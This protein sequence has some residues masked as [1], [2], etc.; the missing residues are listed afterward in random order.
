MSIDAIPLGG[1]T[2]RERARFIRG[3]IDYP[4]RLYAG[5]PKW[6]PWLD[7]DLRIILERRHPFFLTGE[8]EFFLAREDG[9]AVGRIMVLDIPAYRTQHGSNQA[10]FY[11]F[12][13]D[14]AA[15]AAVLVGRLS[16]G[17][18]P[19]GGPLW[20]DPSSSAEPPGRASWWKASTVRRR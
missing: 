13:F 17:P 4:K 6:V 11:F 18:Q 10:F 3:F 15:A 16:L 12:D 2:D 14:S 5:D 7:A 1:L 9:A 20:R 19:G 8:A